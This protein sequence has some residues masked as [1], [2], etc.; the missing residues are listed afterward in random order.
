VAQRVALTQAVRQL[1]KLGRTIEGEYVVIE[2]GISTLFKGEAAVI[3]KQLPKE[4]P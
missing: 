2:Q 3:I 1:P 4:K